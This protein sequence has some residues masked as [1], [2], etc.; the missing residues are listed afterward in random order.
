MAIKKRDSGNQNVL[1]ENAFINGASADALTTSP[2]ATRNYKSHTLAMNQYEYELL[3]Q[4]AEKFGQ[5]HS[6][7]IRYALKKLSEEN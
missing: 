7:V 1:D 2:K 5:S 6:G 3:Q 4:L